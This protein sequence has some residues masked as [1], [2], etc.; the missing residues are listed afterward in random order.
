MAD[1]KFG[2]AKK[3][4]VQ[5]HMIAGQKVRGVVRSDEHGCPPGCW[6]INQKAGQTTTMGGVLASSEND[7]ENETQDLFANVQ[8]RL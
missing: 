8:K 7:I 6:K 3:G 4:E 2:K 5:S 1:A